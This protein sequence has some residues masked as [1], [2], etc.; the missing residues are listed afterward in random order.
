MPS[1]L[2]VHVYDN[3]EQYKQFVI[4]CTD[5]H[6]NATTLPDV[7]TRLQHNLVKPNM[8]SKEQFTSFISKRNGDLQ[9]AEIFP[10]FKTEEW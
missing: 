7:I 6:I 1:K 5:T 9:F 8:V 2:K 4:G 3:L 10:E